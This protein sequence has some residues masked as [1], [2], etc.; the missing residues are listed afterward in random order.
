MVDL[1]KKV[2]PKGKKKEAPD[3]TPQSIPPEPSPEAALGAPPLKGAPQDLGYEA[4]AYGGPEEVTEP[5]P[6]PWEA[7]ESSEAPPF[8]EQY[9]EPYAE[10]GEL[11]EARAPPPAPGMSTE[12]VHNIA[13][14]IADGVKQEL[15]EKIQSLEEEITK[16]KKLDAQTK[17]I[18]T[19]MESIEKK[20]EELERGIGPEAGADLKEIKE[21]IS[22]LNQIITTALPALIKKIQDISASLKTKKT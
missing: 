11:L 7:P 10:P 2:L 17:K 18:V 9:R 22:N 1:L 5:S 15:E 21:N 14:S 12:D 19:S 6:L 20:Y 8:E 3:E 4:P 13:K 16:I